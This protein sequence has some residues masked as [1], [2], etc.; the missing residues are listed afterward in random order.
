MK[1]VYKQAAQGDV[2]FIIRDELPPGLVEVKRKGALVVAHSE[3]GHHHSIE[4]QGVRLF[5]K[6]DR[7]PLV[8]FL[9]LG[10]QPAEVIHHRPYDAHEALC[11]HGKFVEVRRQRET[12]P[13][14]LTRRV[15]D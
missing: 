1:N 4:T 9:S 14:G 8:C 11:L 12:T 15:E 13:E 3:T 10:E 5:E 2:L 6:A 7:D